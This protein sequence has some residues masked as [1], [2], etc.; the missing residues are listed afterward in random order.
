MSV[1]EEGLTQNPFSFKEG[2]KKMTQLLP[3][4]LLSTISIFLFLAGFYFDK[5]ALYVSIGGALLMLVIG[6]TLDNSPLETNTGAVAT[7]TSNI[8][9]TVD[10]YTPINETQNSILALI[11]V[12]VGLA[13]VYIPAIDLNKQ[14]YEEE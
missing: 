14:G 13:G 12:V 5:K 8:T 9:T 7:T 6:I 10:T 2:K 1:S 4:V 3:L 11:M